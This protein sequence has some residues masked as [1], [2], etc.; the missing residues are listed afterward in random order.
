MATTCPHYGAELEVEL[1]NE[2]C[3]YAVEDCA[4]Q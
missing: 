3:G 1:A 2:P 4:C